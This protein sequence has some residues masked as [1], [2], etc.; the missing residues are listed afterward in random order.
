MRTGTN[1]MSVWLAALC[2]ISLPASTLLAASPDPS[3]M[4][5]SAL[6]WVKGQQ[7]PDGSFPGFGPGSTVDAALA[8]L[9]D[10]QDLSA[11]VKG[12][13]TPLTYLQS[14][15]GEL[16]KT[17]GG[18]GKLLVVVAAGGANPNSFGGVNLVENV[19]KSYNQSTG[20]YG[21]DAIGHAFAMLG[22]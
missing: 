16:A 18:A 13:N 5:H 20:Q 12:G 15:A 14:K 22:L 3:D 2:L 7:Q 6:L 1:V 10:R 11:Y 17:P 21:K 19:N 4:A 9:A 8:I